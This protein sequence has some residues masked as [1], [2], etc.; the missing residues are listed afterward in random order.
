MKCNKA[1]WLPIAILLLLAFWLT[2]LVSCGKK[3][4]TK[5]AVADSLFAKAYS[6]QANGDVLASLKV[7]DEIIKTYP[8]HPKIDKAYFMRGFIKY[9]SLNDKSGALEDLKY[10]VK[11]FPES[12]LTDDA[13]FLI[14]SIESGQDLV[15]SFE[16]KTRGK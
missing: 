8:N 16:Q 15:K 11:R 14:E 10:L 13:T 7:Y 6:A 3:A 12:D 9:E 5:S 1:G 2:T 4:E